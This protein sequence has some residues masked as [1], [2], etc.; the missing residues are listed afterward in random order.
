M[1]FTFVAAV[2]TTNWLGRNNGHCYAQKVIWVAGTG[3]PSLHWLGW[4]KWPIHTPSVLKIK[5]RTSA[6]LEQQIRSATYYVRERL[7]SNS[8]VRPLKMVQSSYTW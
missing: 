4:P 7:P 5:H 3:L 8:I 6:W 2:A 1:A